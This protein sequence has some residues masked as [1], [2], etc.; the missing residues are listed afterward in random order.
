ML[1]GMLCL[2]QEFSDF[3]SLC[4]GLGEGVLYD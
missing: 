3:S 4:V 1:Y 2:T